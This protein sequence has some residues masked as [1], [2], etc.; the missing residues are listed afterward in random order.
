MKLIDMDLSNMSYKAIKEEFD[1]IKLDVNDDNILNLSEILLND[2]RKNVQSLGSRIIKEKK[3]LEDEIIRVKTMYD[4]DRSFSNGRLLAGV[5]EVGR[6]PLAGPIVSASV[7]LDLECLDEGMILY[8][9]DSKKL[10]E[11]KREELSDIIKDK[12]ISYCISE[13]SNDEIDEKGIGFCNNE[14]FLK[15][16]GGLKEVPS[17]VL[18]DGYKVRGIDIE[19][20]W[21]IK[22][23]TKSAAIAAASIIAKVYRDNLMKEIAKKYPEYGFESNVGYG[24]KKHID[25]IKEHGATEIHRMSFLSNIL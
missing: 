15:A 21:V 10:S 19:N 4:F 11:K 20:K 25:A 14:V 9:N 17:I 13:C 1:M 18:S 7:I 16:I 22:G 3:K 8:L 12:A 5:D 23:D 6:G 2:K 24:A